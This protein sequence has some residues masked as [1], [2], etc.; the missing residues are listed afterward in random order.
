MPGRQSAPGLA[1]HLMRAAA[2][3][4]VAYPGIRCAPRHFALLTRASDAHRDT[5]RCLPG[6]LM[7]TAAL[8]IV[9]PG[10]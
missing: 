6:H 1:G 8:C 9:Y 2:L 7:R 3:C 5:L 4:C 10:I